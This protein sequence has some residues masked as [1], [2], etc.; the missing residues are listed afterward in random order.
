[1]F[2]K[3]G[4]CLKMEDGVKGGESGPRVE[5]IEEASMVELDYGERCVRSGGNGGWK[6][7]TLLLNN[8]NVE[9]VVYLSRSFCLT[10]F[11]CLFVMVRASSCEC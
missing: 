4:L 11:F 5:L 9:V 6:W 10:G 3:S 1:M 7:F 2:A 8:I